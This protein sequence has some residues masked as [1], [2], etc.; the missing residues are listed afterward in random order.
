MPTSSASRP[1]FLAAILFGAAIA[2][3]SLGAHADEKPEAA[4][5]CTTKKFATPQVEKACK[6]G[7]QPAAKKM[8]K[9]LVKKAKAKGEKI[10]C[11]SCHKNIKDY[12]LTDD[13]VDLLKKML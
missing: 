9:A 11:K 3:V 13:G 1:G 6:E 8:M 7:G 10:K 12:A 5:P 2:G 4:K